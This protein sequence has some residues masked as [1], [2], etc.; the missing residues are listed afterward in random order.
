MK[1][2]LGKPMLF[3]QIERVR[4]AHK[5]GK[6]VIATSNHPSDDCIEE[7]CFSMPVG[8][9]RGS[10]INVL[11]RYYCAARLH[12]PAHVV[13]LTGDC[14][15]ADPRLIDTMIEQHLR[16]GNDYTFI[17]QTHG[18]QHGLDAEIMT[19]AALETSRSNASDPYEREHVTPYI[20]KHPE[21]FRIGTV[22]S[23]ADFSSYRWTVDTADDFAFV[24]QVYEILYP[25]N[26]Q[27][28]TEDIMDLLEQ[29]P[30]LQKINAC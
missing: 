18:H 23:P 21:H 16:E 1:P 15:L 14:P 10:L 3:R 7:L 25:K 6:L 2:I 20:K 8:C 4:R 19:F 29:Q 9:F 12:Q 11:E 22:A 30:Q 24:R 13:R 27:F 17:G 26:P 5:I 28:S